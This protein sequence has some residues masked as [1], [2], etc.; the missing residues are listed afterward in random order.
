MESSRAYG[1]FPYQI[2]KAFQMPSR[3]SKQEHARTHVQHVWRHAAALAVAPPHRQQHHAKQRARGY[4]D[5]ADGY[6]HPR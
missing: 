6:I 1:A 4:A 2:Q 5:G 3:V